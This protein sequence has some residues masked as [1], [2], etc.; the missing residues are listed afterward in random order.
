MD[1]DDPDKQVEEVKTQRIRDLQLRVERGRK[2]INDCRFK[3]ACARA[4]QC[5]GVC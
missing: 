4:T 3:D 1:A 2:G 5:P